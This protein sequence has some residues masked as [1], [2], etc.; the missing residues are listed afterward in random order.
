MSHSKTYCKNCIDNKSSIFHHLKNDE[1]DLLSVRHTITYYRKG[2]LIYKEGDRPIG[3]L[4]LSEGKVKVMKE[5]VGGRE[6]IVR[7]SKP[8][9]FIGYRALFA[10]DQYVFSAMAIFSLRVIEP[11]GRRQGDI[12]RRPKAKGIRRKEF[13]VG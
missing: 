9:G 2:E 4:F 12:M 5:G 10:G 8:S 7:M 3:L 11:Q 13:S 6:Q 1:K